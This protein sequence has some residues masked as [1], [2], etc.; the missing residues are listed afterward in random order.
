MLSGP[1]HTRSPRYTSP[2]TTVTEK[3]LFQDYSHGPWTRP[4]I[5]THSSIANRYWNGTNKINSTNQSEIVPDK[6]KVYEQQNNT[7]CSKGAWGEESNCDHQVPCGK[8]YVESYD[9]KPIVVVVWS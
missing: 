1:A 8:A 7:L 9:F 6:V 3:V 5:P 2:V 4:E